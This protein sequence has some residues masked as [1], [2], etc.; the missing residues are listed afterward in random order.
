LAADSDHQRY[1]IGIV[2]GVLLFDNALRPPQE[3]ID[4]EGLARGRRIGEKKLVEIVGSCAAPNLS[5]REVAL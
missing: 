2:G 3:L 4:R 5:Q 1:A